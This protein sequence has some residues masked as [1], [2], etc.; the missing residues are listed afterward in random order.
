MGANFAHQKVREPVLPIF[1]IGADSRELIL[2]EHLIIF[3][4]LCSG[5]SDL[6][7][8]NSWLTVLLEKLVE[9]RFF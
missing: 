5:V 7:R 1:D 8:N 2:D 3:T 9:S 6:S 4:N